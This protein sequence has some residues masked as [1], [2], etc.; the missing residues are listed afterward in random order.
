MGVLVVLQIFVVMAS[1]VISRVWPP[2]WRL[3]GAEPH[4]HLMV[5]DPLYILLRVVSDAVVVLT[6][7][8]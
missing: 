6:Y 7:P 8:S 1:S 4:A 2:A 5:F 3:E